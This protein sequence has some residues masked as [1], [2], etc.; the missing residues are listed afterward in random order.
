MFLPI[1]VYENANMQTS[2]HA[3]LIILA[4]IWNDC[5]FPG[6]QMVQYS[7]CSGIGSPACVM[8]NEGVSKLSE[9]RVSLLSLRPKV[10]RT[11]PCGIRKF[12]VSLALVYLKEYCPF[13]G[14]SGK[15][16]CP[17]LGISWRN[18]APL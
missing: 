12:P 10:V 2:L 14:F 6:Q 11:V 1:I 8:C 16:K 7:M 5:A 13:V 3:K 18:G 9:R 17:T 4:T 15:K